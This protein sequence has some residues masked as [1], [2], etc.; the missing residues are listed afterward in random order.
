MSL[1][2]AF[3][4]VIPSATISLNFALDGYQIR[5]RELTGHDERRVSGTSTEDA[6][7]LLDAVILPLVDEGPPLRAEDLVAADRDRVLAALYIQTFGDRI[8]NTLN[9]EACELP[10]DIHFSLCDLT[11]TLEKRPRNPQFVPVGITTFESADGWRFR[12]PT[13]CDERA[14]AAAPSRTAESILAE[15][16]MPDTETRPDLAVLQAAL[17]EVAPLL[18]FE[19][20]ASCPECGR[21]HLVQFDI[22]TYLLRSLLND[23]LH[24]LSDIHRLAAAYTWSANEILNLTR[25]ERRRLVELVEND[26]SHRRISR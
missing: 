23:Q 21:V 20:K 19:L 25:T 9:C 6:L 15:R 13:G 11:A 1:P 7:E 18:E 5:L 24:L 16:C 8:E 17:D 22:Q 2:D 4:R 12:L 14:A 3:R 26:S 10:F